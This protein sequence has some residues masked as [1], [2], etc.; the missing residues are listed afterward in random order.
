MATRPEEKA[1]EDID[2]LLARAGWNVQHVREANI[3]AARG[4]A[5]REFKL[6]E[7]F[8]FADYM[9]YVDGRAAG[10]IEY[11]LQ[12]NASRA[13]RGREIIV[14]SDALRAPRQSK[15]SG[16]DKALQSICGKGFFGTPLTNHKRPR[17]SLR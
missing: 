15:V 1:R 13:Y 10:V 3:R 9:L 2:R 11:D 6:N 16:V 7:G 17:A 8:G 5:L 14:L 12:Y 4:V